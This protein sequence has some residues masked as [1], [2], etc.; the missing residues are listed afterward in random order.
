MRPLFTE[1]L[2]PCR[3]SCPG[4]VDIP[5][6]IDRIQMGD[7]EGAWRVILE[8]NPLPRITG[9]VC[10][11]PCEGGC[12]RRDYDQGI[13]IHSL[14]RFVGDRAFEQGL[15]SFDEPSR[16]GKKVA[17][18]GTGPAGIGCAFHLLKNGY[19]VSVFEAMPETGG[20]LRYGIP[21]YRLPKKIL[22]Q[23]LEIVLG[24][25]AE[26]HQG[27]RAGADV[28][29]AEL[30]ADY[31]G[32]FL[33]TGAQKPISLGIA[34]EAQ[35]AVIDGLSFLRNGWQRPLFAPGQTVLIIGGGNT[36]IDVARTVLRLKGIPLVLYRRTREEMPAFEDEIQEAE[37]EGIEIRFLISP[38]AIVR[39]MDAVKGLECIKN[40][41]TEAGTDGRRRFA[42]IKGSEFF[43][44]GD[45]VIAALG[46]QVGSED[47]PREVVVRDDAVV[48]AGDGSCGPGGIYAGGD[49]TDLPRSVIHALA[50]GKKAAKALDTY[51][52]DKE[53]PVS[54][55]RETS[56]PVTL[57]E[58]NLAYFKPAS[59]EAPP[60]QEAAQRI[61]GVEEITGT[62][63]SDAAAR[64]ADRCFGCGHCTTC[65]NCYF[66][67]PDFAVHQDVE[68][69]TIVID[70]EYC[71]GCCICVEECPRGVLSAEVKR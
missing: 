31:Q 65:G 61:S 30:L 4:A 56:S 58:I 50:S 26:I 28:S 35:G 63:F 23:E 45:I 53:K 44:Q 42:P 19:R 69:S 24:P 36:A 43:I 21:E 14:E 12:S 70:S 10:Y 47:L 49:V 8:D 62:Y 32:L 54:E 52:R 40:C 1:K 17:V 2:A 22:S 25:G 67:C 29:W 5:R 16:N 59:R 11:H 48:A 9:R 6:F 37:E 46:Q 39:E 27:V 20:L 57:E 71:K 41:I 66:F 33:G 15:I 3:S 68:M 64:E 34:G 51:L 18:V 60:I 7:L 13:G 38:K 55:D